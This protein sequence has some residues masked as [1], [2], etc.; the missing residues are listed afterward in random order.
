MAM[1]GLLL[2]GIMMMTTLSPPVRGRAPVL[3]TST[4]WAQ[5]EAL[6][7]IAS[8]V[9]SNFALLDDEQKNSYPQLHRKAQASLEAVEDEIKRI[10]DTFKSTQISSLKRELKSLTGLDINPE[11]ARIYTRY[12][13][14]IQQDFNE[15]LA[16]ISGDKPAREPK[17]TFSP[18]RTARALD[19]SRF[20][21]RIHSV[22]LWEAA[23]EN[24]SYRT[25][26]VLLKPYS[27]E[28]ASYIDYVQGMTGQSAGPFIAIA[29][30][31]DLGAQL[32]HLLEEAAG[33]AGTLM[34]RVVDAAEATFEFELLEA[35]RNNALSKVQRRE[36][37]Q[38][39]AMLKGNAAPHIWPVSMG[40]AK[41]H[42]FIHPPTDTGAD[43]RLLFG[44]DDGYDFTGKGS[45][46]LP[47]FIIKVPGIIGVFSY[48]PNRL[49]GAVLWHTNVGAVFQQFVQQL[50][51]DHSKGQLGWFIRQ[52][53]FKDLGF[54]NKLL[55]DEPRPVGMSWLAGVLYDSF[56]ST[57]PEPNLDSLRLSVE[58]SAGGSRPL[59]QAMAERQMERYR[60]NLSLLAMR[61][62][63]QDW[64]AFK[65]ALT[66]I[67]SEVLSLLT[68]PMP[69][70]VLG[71][72][73]IMQ[74]AILG[75][76][77]HSIV[78][79]VREAGKGE[80]STF[81]SALADSIDML[82]SGHLTG[83]ASKAH[84]QRMS[85]L[86][87]NVGQPRKVTHADGTTELWNRDLSL[88]SPIDPLLLNTLTPSLEGLYQHEG[89]AYARVQE[90][91]QS[92]AVEV[93]L[94]PVSNRYVLAAGNAQVYR[95]GVVFDPVAR[96]WGLALDDVHGLSDAQ[97]LHRMLAVESPG[98]GLAD[99]EQMLSITATSREQLQDTWR[100]KPIP[101]PL[102]DGVR[103]LM[104]DRLIEH[105]V[106]G[107][108]LHADMPLSA[109]GAVLSVLTQLEHWPA[110]AVLDV[111]DP[112]GAVIESYGK[113]YRPGTPLARIV[114]KRLDHGSYVAKDDATEGRTQLQDL[115]AMILDQLPEATRLGRESNPGLDKAGRIAAIGRQ[116]A[117]L[118]REDKP[119]LFKAL[120]GLEGHQRS[121]PIASAD[122]GRKY[123]P[124]ACPP[125]SESTTPL[126]A[127]LHELNP[128]LS[129]ESIETLLVTHPFT[130]Y[131]V[132]RALEYNAQPLPFAAA[133]DLLKIKLRVDQALDGIYHARAYTRDIDAWARE[134]A[135]GALHDKLNRRLVITD[136][137]DPSQ[138][139][140]HVF[141]GPDDTTVVLRHHG[142]GV[143]E[144]QDPRRQ[145]STTFSSTPDSFYLALTWTLKLHERSLLGMQGISI[146]GLRKAL[147]DAML[148]NRQPGGEVNL[149]DKTTAQ[150]QRAVVL[151]LDQPPGELGLY[152]IEG[153][154][155]LSLYGVVYQVEFDTALHK[156]R[157]KHPEKTGVNTPILE[158]NGDGAWRQKIEN[159][160][161]WS[162]LKLLR[163]LRAE[164]QSFNDEAGHAIMAVSDTDEGVLRQ[165]HMNNLT[166]PPL[167]IDT[168]KRF[169]IDRDI[170][171]FVQKMQAYHSLGDARSDLQLLLMQSLPGWPRDKVLEVL[172]A[173]GNTLQQYG[174]DL[175]SS[176]PR[177]RIARD[178]TR[179]GNL[180]R[181]LLSRM[182]EADTRVLLDE[183]PPVLEARVLALAKK[184]AAHGL[185]RAAHL[186]RSVYES[187]E[188]SSDAR[189]VLVQ[190]KYPQLPKSVIEHL[191][192]HTTGHEKAH[193][194]DKGMIAPRLAEQI[195]WSAREV[196]VARAYEGLYLDAA[197]TPD[198][199]RLTLH[200]LQSLPGWPADI[201][202]EVR[203][204]DVNG[205]LLDSIGA[206]AAPARILVRHDDR[207]RA[208]TPEGQA[209]NAAS[210]ID[211]NLL[212]SILHALNETERASI[213]IQDA[214]DTQA[215]ARKISDQAVTHRAQVK[216]LLGL[217]PLE[218]RAK[219]PMKVDISFVAYP[220][221]LSQGASRQPLDLVRQVR[222]LYPSWSYEAVLHFLETLGGTDASR[223]AEV[224]RLR[225]EFETLQTQLA[226]WERI[227]L[228]PTA[229][230]H[231]AM[232]LP[233][234]RRRVCERIERAW[235]RETDII[236][237]QTGGSGGYSLDLTGILAGD[238]PQLTGDFSHI[239][240][241]HMDNMNLYRGSDAFLSH[242]SQLR[243]LS[244]SDNYLR[245]LPPAIGSMPQLTTLNLRYN[246]ITLTPESV[247][248][249]AGCTALQAL[250][251][252]NNQLS[253]APDVGQMTQLRILDLAYTGI[254]QWPAGVQGLAHID[255]VN[256]RHNQIAIIPQALFEAPAA[257]AVN[258]VTWIHDNPISV[259]SRDR[260][261]EY[262]GR[263]GIH[264]GFIPAVAHAH[265]LANARAQAGD[266]TPWLS[267]DLNVAQREQKIQQWNLLRGFEGKAGDFLKLLAGLALA[268]TD[269]SGQ[270]RLALRGRVWSLIDSLLAD[271]ALR[272]L[273][274]LGIHYDATCRDG[275]MVLLD[276]LEVQVLIHRAENL[277]G[278]G[279][280]EAQHLNLAR[281]LFRLRQVDRIADAV[282]AER[283]KLGG[284]PDVAEI[285]LFYRIE[286]A[287]DLS[288]PIQTR[289]MF[290]APIAGIS[291]AQITEA[292]N[293]ILA[294]DTSPA[295]KHSIMQEA[296]WRNFLQAKHAARFEIIE[297]QYQRDYT[298]LSEETGTSNDVQLQRGAELTNAR[299]QMLNLLVEELTDRALQSTDQTQ[300]GPLSPT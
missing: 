142:N 186:L 62:S 157:F 28:Q 89:K 55:S 123:L 176:V 193:F 75:S 93:T 291:A 220:I 135:R 179:N 35:F 207:Y 187:Q 15:Y 294:M 168:W 56:R 250:R 235:R 236:S 289:S 243:V 284:H 128:S 151:A 170:Q 275:V 242:F 182:N 12:R 248:Q 70:G 76:L 200:M 127:K 90:G 202:I 144:V 251:L 50:K 39:L 115:L 141:S 32:Q 40:L 162:T 290:S 174:S 121:D 126:L 279:L 188:K 49:N 11:Q 199:E 281:G 183:S 259:E 71:L 169:A 171:V 129:I 204:S 180:L 27:Y 237:V 273:L 190:D 213:S 14:N 87:N 172:D 73:R 102:A 3:L 261:I 224:E 221:W 198:S 54:F 133:A 205:Q 107:L 6:S 201:R 46:P 266:I 91:D 63:D 92:L 19:E 265:A 239:R 285:Q 130:A 277:A 59:A 154:K 148:A 139:S 185:K 22:T 106:S 203:S 51:H 57:F 254:T 278:E 175:S 256:L 97:L 292:K 1:L 47:L 298:K 147:G 95:P 43:G 219:P 249:L 246:R 209:L 72:N 194:L 300:P 116:I 282:V 112:Q 105:I 25:D 146:A 167:L 295:L 268:Q 98:S 286:L 101:G 260:L 66:D 196:R 111:L 214:S 79:G 26:S 52:L 125:I 274:F 37:E 85:T 160:L 10:K 17:Y 7:F 83:V 41:K 113:D 233:G 68:T 218:S 134:F 156:W 163:R 247:Q 223:R 252:D 5:N 228:Y 82:I 245:A 16:R 61:K 153:K 225:V 88:Y 67:G 270:I 178:E 293:R 96:V 103:R 206:A 297:N 138:A 208:Y 191:L 124:L 44:S 257:N 158:H 24:F 100:G 104:A 109:V 2:N 226:S 31:L 8:I 240:S 69:G 60:S 189:V 34:R 272:D 164:P 30:K 36:H 80:A 29:R 140:A 215:L 212:S 229:G 118:A 38:L 23:C 280:R 122:A 244:M 264:M 42:R 21:E 230:S 227:Q 184:I 263:T 53:A 166:P 86:W 238:L 20:I 253:F 99:I 136:A 33:P 13:E 81:A 165:V 45:V 58:M 287:E 143:Y 296:L 77:A 216:T 150:Y 258:S 299:D 181:A 232:A 211:N 84:R 269:M 155:Y 18:S 9:Q 131:Q 195:V 149:W 78:Q 197:A 48:F 222:S 65:E 262:W 120:T 231:V 288:L 234:E 64:Q 145:G 114:I 177:I 192:G 4:Q 108:P 241:L 137:L 159:P 152:E 94:D 161:Q 283:L 173:Q 119:L 267:Q 276:N 110:D 210:A 117:A 74:G 217:E 255:E 271:T 132:T